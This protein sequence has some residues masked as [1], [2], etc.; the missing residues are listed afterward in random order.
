MKKLILPFIVFLIGLVIADY[1]FKIDVMEM[2][3]GTGD[4]IMNILKGPGSN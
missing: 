2:I 4:F 1:F 3:E